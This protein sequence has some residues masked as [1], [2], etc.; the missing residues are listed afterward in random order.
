MKT[1]LQTKENKLVLSLTIL[2]LLTVNYI[3]S[4]FIDRHLTDITAYDSLGFWLMISNFT[5][6][7]LIVIG[8]KKYANLKW[9]DLGLGKPQN[10]WQPILVFVGLYVAFQLFAR[11]VSPEIVKL[12][13]RP[14][15]SHLMSLKGNMQGLV[16]ALVVVWITAAFLEELIFRGFLLNAIN[17][18]LGSTKWS[19]WASVV[20]SSVIFGLIH[21]YQGITGILITGSVGFIFGLAFIINGRRLWPVMLMHGIIDTISFI[22][23]YQMEAL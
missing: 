17:K 23:I 5:L 19:M 22:S 2:L 1:A 10:W 20:I 14:N 4:I 11:Y 15:V 8:Y 7:T 12:G 13:D 6:M 16:I 18:L 9:R 3:I 21:A